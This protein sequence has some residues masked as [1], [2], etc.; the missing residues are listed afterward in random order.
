[1]AGKRDVDE[2]TN[3]QTTGHE[4]DGIKE[5]DTPM[6]RWWLWSL[7]ATIVWGVIYLFLMPAWPLI[8]GATPGLLGYSS[9][10]AVERDIAEA[11][12]VNAPLDAQLM[13]VD[14][15]SIA[16]DPDMLRYAIA[17]GGAV[18]RNNCSQCHGAGGQ[19]ALG[20]YPNLV[21]DD[22]LWGG[23]TE[24]IYQT[25]THGIRYEADPDTRFSQMPA[26]GDILEADEIAGL[27]E[28]V[29][30]LS[31]ADHDADL[32]AAHQQTFIDNCSACHGEDGTGM[33]DQGAPNLTDGI[34]LYGG[35]RD[36]IVATIT[37]A[38]Y[39]IMPAFQN[40]LTDAEIRKVAVYVHGLGGGE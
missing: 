32:A 12:A 30:S 9:R 8:N 31:G 3:T 20:G 35:D 25:V 16:E 2:A 21:D 34:W 22:W 37:N 4:W 40:R 1:M 27:A 11:E 24:E 10:G 15:A 6:P 17:G 39:G 13:S 26:F 33:R 7:Y 19:G 23:T 36:T 29:L 5:L 38:R 28:Y 18:F 14:I